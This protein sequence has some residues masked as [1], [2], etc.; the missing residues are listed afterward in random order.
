MVLFDMELQLC[1]VSADPAAMLSK[2]AAEDLHMRDV[3][4]KDTLTVCLRI[5][6]AKYGK[7]RRIFERNG[8][9][10]QITGKYGLVWRALSLFHRPAMTVGIGVFILIAWLA[11]QR[12]FL[13]RVSGNERI[14]AREIA[15]Y[16]QQSGICF[17]A[18]SKDVRSEQV[19]NSLLGQM[20]ALQWLGVTTSG[21]VAT[22]HVKE[23]SVDTPQP[24]TGHKVSSIVAARSGVVS[25][26]LISHGTSL[27]TA[28]QSVQSGDVLISGYTDCGRVIKAENAKG[29]VYAYTQYKIQAISLFPSY[30]RGDKGEEHTCYWL[31]L[32]KKVINL[33]N[34]SGIWDPTC[35]KMYTEDFCTFPGGLTL[36]ICLIK[37]RYI[38]YTESVDMKDT[39]D[40]EWMSAGVQ[41]QLLSQ[42]TAGQ[43]LDEVTL[44]H[45][46]DGVCCLT[47]EYACHEMI[48]RVKC[49]ET[50]EG[51]AQDY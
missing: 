26:I 16:A 32:G 35:V 25:E 19:K 44:L 20:P 17:G 46:R 30:V 6:V 9:K 36:P 1:F 27:V 11:S 23:R 48:G 45:I 34:H 13:V 21:G 33:C 15:Y 42:M 51:Y 39:W 2:L 31:R 49:E 3:A 37:E 12:I 18:K 47:G 28:G 29:E 8:I 4:Y 24:D 14:P 7:I 41:K 22:I 5:P 43:I 40:F 10:F 38:L 50:V